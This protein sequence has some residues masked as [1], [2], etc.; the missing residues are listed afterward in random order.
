[1]TSVERIFEPDPAMQPR[2]DAMFDAY[3]SAINAL[4]PIGL[5]RTDGLVPRK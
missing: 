5:I 3:I 1:M 4:R 2:Y